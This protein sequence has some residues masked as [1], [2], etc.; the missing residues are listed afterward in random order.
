MKTY[1]LKHA[2]VLLLL[3]GCLSSCIEKKSTNEVNVKLL[4]SFEDGQIAPFIAS[5]PNAE[6]VEVDYATDGTKALR[7]SYGR[8]TWDQ[9]NQ[10][11]QDYDFLMVDVYLEG[12]TPL[13]FSIAVYDKDTDYTD[14][15]YW[16]RIN[17]YTT[18]KLGKNTFR[19]P[20]DSPVESKSRPGRPFLKNAVTRLDF[21][22]SGRGGNASVYLDNI[23]VVKDTQG[24]A[25]FD[26]VKAFSFGD[27][28]L[29]VMGGFTRVSKDCQYSDGQGYGWKNAEVKCPIDPFQPDILYRN[30]IYVTK[31]DFIID[32]PNGKYHVFMNIDAPAGYWGDM[33][34]YRTRRVLANGKEVVNDKMDRETALAKYFRYAHTEDLYNDDVFEKYV[35]PHYQEKEF[36]VEVSDGRLMLS[37]QGDLVQFLWD[38][39]QGES[40]AIALS[41]LIIYPANK[42]K[43][44]KKYLAEI[45]ERRRADFDYTSN[46][47]LT[48]DN[49]PEPTLNEAQRK[50]GY[51]IFSRSVEDDIY[52]DTRPVADELTDFVS[53]AGAAGTM[54][55]MTFAIRAYRDFGDVKVSAGDFKTDDG[56]VIPSGAIQVGYVSNRLLRMDLNGNAYTIRPRYIMDQNQI[57][58]PENTTRWFYVK[59]DVPETA[60]K[61]LYMGEFNLEFGN[62]EK[63][64]LA[65]AFEVV[66]DKALPKLDIPVGPWGFEMRLAAWYPDEMNDFRQKLNKASADMLRKAGFTTFSVS[67]DIKPEGKGK[68]MKLNFDRADYW[69][70]LAREYGMTALVN[71][72][73]AFQPDENGKSLNVY[74]Y[75]IPTDPKDFG[76]DDDDA[77]WKYIIELIDKHAQEKQWLPLF[78]ISCDE[79]HISIDQKNSAALNKIFKKY[80]TSRIRFAGDTSMSENDKGTFQQEFCESMD[81]ANLDTHDQW[82]ID[83][84][85]KAGSDWGFYN[86]IVSRWTFGPYMFMLAQKH[87]MLFRLTWHWNCNKG[88][89]YYALDGREDDFCWANTN[90]EGGVVTSLMFERL[91][92]GVVDYR[93]LL[94]LKNFVAEKPN[95]PMVK[96]AQA[97]FDEVMALKPAEDRNRLRRAQEFRDKTITILKS[98]N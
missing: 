7:F 83:M 61:G 63:E 70:K 36:D 78:I 28:K 68:D 21:N 81:V 43:A 94:A 15:P 86:G 6:I 88:D 41:A 57:A 98:I 64:K 71:Y 22:L 82:A 40:S 66:Y 20:L 95:H 89:P 11:W 38:T 54:E 84:L 3:A 77:L 39:A 50:Q 23:R 96:D 5:D 65:A 51:V 53:A 93:Y 47:V 17:Y 37:F 4:D 8:V 12:D 62:G 69:M 34:I 2:T 13:N 75:P 46:K 31:G 56:K 18:L 72:G 45:K 80:S 10:N 91:C 29:P 26:G 79:P 9:A 25:W 49:N 67:L 30:V 1:I 27:P 97:L 87:K 55:P 60:G 44:G 59:F 92:R 73:V 33:P 76:F 52:P 32:L 19:I 48:V 14:N 74:G 16:T 35:T 24:K 42:Q 90:A 85:H 58:L